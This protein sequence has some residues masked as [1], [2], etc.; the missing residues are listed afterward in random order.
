MVTLMMHYDA[1]VAT[2]PSLD[3]ASVKLHLRRSCHRKPESYGVNFPAP[4]RLILL[5]DS[6]E[7]P[8]RN[9]DKPP[10]RT[11]AVC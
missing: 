10:Q 5:K 7:S 3:H 4:R 1:Y 2:P 6:G 9:D 11:V 8:L